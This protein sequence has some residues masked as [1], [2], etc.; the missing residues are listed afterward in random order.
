MENDYRS[1]KTFLNNTDDIDG[2]CESDAVVFIDWREYDEDIV[3]Y[4]NQKTNNKIRVE[5]QD[6]GKSYGDDIVLK[7]QEKTIAIPY[8][9]KMDRDTTIIYTN[10]IVRSDYEI[11]WCTDS[12]GSD[13][14]GFVILEKPM[15][16][17]LE[18]IFGQDK[19]RYYF[20][21]VFPGK[22]MFRLDIDEVFALMNSRKKNRF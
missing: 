6:N 3:Y 1:I 14:L 7:Y 18:A 15:W 22:K 8:D 10:E 13:T 4:F 21:P 20:E 12:L 11:R 9:E 16:E 19:V 17:N 2:L 5:M